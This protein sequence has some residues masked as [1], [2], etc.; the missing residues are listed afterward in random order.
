MNEYYEMMAA[1]LDRE[2]R[3]QTQLLRQQQDQAY[4]ESL[5]VDREKE[6]EKQELVEAKKR[7]IEADKR[8]QDEEKQRIKVNKRFDL[9]IY[10]KPFLWENIFKFCF[11]LKENNGEKK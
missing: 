6:R 10:F 5:L 2:Q 7:E 8:K 4:Q 1:R 9:F 3:I 11:F